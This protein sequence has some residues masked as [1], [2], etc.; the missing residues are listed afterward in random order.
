MTKIYYN[1]LIESNVAVPDDMPVRVA[2]TAIA[3]GFNPEE[4][5]SQ[6]KIAPHTSDQTD[7]TGLFV[8]VSCAAFNFD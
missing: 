3:L 4:E 2:V 6:S 7:N 5:L 8:F 1:T